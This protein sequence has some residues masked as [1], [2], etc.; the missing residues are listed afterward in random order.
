MWR[1]CVWQ[2]FY[3]NTKIPYRSRVF[4]DLM[5]SDI[6]ASYMATFN[7][8]FIKALFRT[9]KFNNSISLSTF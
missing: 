3:E 6:K 9:K 1:V 2:Y 8:N 5:K 7:K 4:R